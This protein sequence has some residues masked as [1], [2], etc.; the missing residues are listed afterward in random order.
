M[1]SLL[2]PLHTVVRKLLRSPMFTVISVLTLAIGIGANAAIFTV[3]QGVLIRPLPFPESERL[4]GVWHTAPGIELPQFEQ[5]DATYLLYRRHNRFFE[6][7]GIYDPAT[8]NLTGGERPERLPSADVTASLFPLLRI[9][10]ALGR[11][12]DEGDERPGAEPVVLIGHELWTR[13]FGAEEHIL[14]Q[15]IQVDG[16]ARTV[17]G[18]MP[19]GFHFPSP[20]TLLW[21]P[22]EIDPANANVGNFSFPGIGRL[23]PDATPAAAE[24]DLSA[25]I[26]RLPEEF[27]DDDITPGM[28]K[29]AGIAA[30]VHPLRDDVVGD[31]GKALWLLLGAVGFILLIACANVANLFLV[32]A[33]GRQREVAIRTALGA[34]RRNVVLAFLTES[35]VLAIAGGALGLALAAAGIRVFLAIG[36]QSIPRLEAIGI[37]GGVLAFT[38]AISFLAALLFGVMPALRGGAPRPGTVLKEGGRGST[39][40]RARH[41][42]RYALVAAQVALAL[43]L[44]VGSGLMARSF[45]ALQA[46]EPGFD[47]S[48]LLTVRLSLPMAEYASA[49][50]RAHFFQTTVDRLRTLPGVDTAGAVTRLPLGDGGS[51][52][53]HTFEDFPLEPDEVPRIISTRRVAPGYFETLRIPLIEGRVLEPA[54][55]QRQSRVALVSEALARQMWG[56]TSPLGKRLTSGIA[57]QGDWFTIVGV[58]GSI[59]DDSLVED[60]TEIVYY[61]LASP[62]PPDE[63]EALA[64]GTMSLVLRTSVPATSVAGAVRS[65]IWDADP[66]LPV[67]NVR[68]MDQI[69][70]RSR[71]RTGFTML[72]LSIAAAVALLL[73]AVGLY[74]VVSYVVSQRTQEIGVRIALGADRGTVSRM[75]VRQGLGMTLAGVVAGLAGAFLLTRFLDGFLYGVDA[76]DPTTFAAVSILLLAIALFATYL[77][78]RRA[79]SVDPLTALRYE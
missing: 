12:F 16:V 2:R 13:R 30:L 71:A 59:R 5:S 26:H 6:D 49:E 56:D 45:R 35:I 17:I 39:T 11:V 10:P 23:R 7:I 31:V 72:L 61:P 38:V 27:P 68:T 66:N 77:P 24:A 73:G 58:V 51:N 50:Q 78:A 76:T 42:A 52:S 64:P 69:L 9:P 43:I 18:V 63:E 57:E 20:E 70:E 48:N 67:A 21:L 37:D 14:E 29:N 28:L 32:R 15:T 47:A 1:D 74:G 25:L 54:D 41:R 44:L 60:P 19:E 3:V 8:V 62:P 36:P 22:M 33:E 34:T 75:V 4:M 79:A 55:H 65:A 40:G 46:V 53:A